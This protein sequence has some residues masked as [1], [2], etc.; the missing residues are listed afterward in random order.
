M[1]FV[2]IE[3]ARAILN[4][5]TFRDASL[6]WRNTMSFSYSKLTVA[7]A[8]CLAGSVA[9]AA[10]VEIYGKVDLGLEYSHVSSDIAGDSDSFKMTNGGSRFGFNI[11]EQINNDWAIRGYLENGFNADDGKFTTSGTLFDRRMIL[12]VQ[13]KTY[14]E[15]GFGR[16]GTVMSTNSPYALGIAYADPFETGYTA[17]YTISGLF[18]T[19]SRANNAITYF[20]PKIAGFKAGVTWSFQR[21][22]QE[23][24]ENDHNDRV[25]AGL[26]TYENG[27]IYVFGGASTIMW[28]NDNEYADR[29]DSV[30][31]TVG[32]CW[33]AMDNLK[34]YLGAQW[35]KDWRTLGYW[36]AEDGS[37]D[38]DGNITWGQENGVDGMA[39]ITGFR[40]MP[41]GQLTL[42]AS[43]GYF[44]GEQD[45]DE[46][47]EDTGNVT[48]SKTWDGKRHR[49][50][51][52]A[53]YDLSKTTTL[54]AVANYTKNSGKMLTEEQKGAF[55]SKYGA[56]VGITHWF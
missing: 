51:I 7:V 16:M 35:M 9:M 55:D 19:D 47:D 34:L 4:I 29:K 26:L 28:G 53:E 40:Y 22:G 13:S 6:G 25:L 33:S 54:Y 3:G 15:M 37:K 43:Y 11:R 45:R 21:A 32:L 1:I 41:T 44:D 17:D 42:I 49:F 5:N 10:D 56:L 50:S 48:G 38:A 2:A 46:F 20:T 12:A 27:P 52:G 18:A 24:E 14:G 36:S 30:E 8:A 39:Y 23:E 31:A